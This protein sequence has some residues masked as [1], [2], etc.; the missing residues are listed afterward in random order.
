MEFQDKVIIITGASAGVGAATARQFFAAGAK[1]MLAARGREA[2][3][4]QAAELGDAQR[5]RISCCDV[6]QM[7]DC[8]RLVDETIAAFGRIDGLVNNAGCNH[9]GAVA[10]NRAADLAQV[11][12]VN[13]R[14]PIVLSNLVLPHLQAAGGGAIVNVA[15]LAGRVPLPHEAS[16]SASKFGLRGFSLAMRDELRG[17]GVTISIVS[18]G[19]IETGFILEDMDSVP[20]L[21]FSQPM[22][23]AEQVATAIIDCARDGRAER[24]IPALSGALTTLGYLVPGIFRLLRPLFERKGARAKQRYRARH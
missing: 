20:D 8:Q 5:V 4:A 17:S 10:E 9:R 22:S 18:P 24:A 13:L 11:I 1:L 2:L 15:S 23:S 12:E 16:Y 7:A 14:A 19:P 3:D 6:G 21:V